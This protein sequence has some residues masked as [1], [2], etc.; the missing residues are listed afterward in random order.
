VSVA[1]PLARWCHSPPTPIDVVIFNCVINLS[2]A[3][4]A[5]LTETYC[6]LTLGGRIGISNVIADD[7]LT[8]KERA[9]C[10]S[11]VG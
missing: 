3:K 9:E 1:D 11:Y 5:V 6:V 7:D 4:P 2:V 10:G 8:T